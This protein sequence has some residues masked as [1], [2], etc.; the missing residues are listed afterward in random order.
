MSA[1]HFLAGAVTGA[2]VLFVVGAAAASA[3]QVEA[4]HD[5]VAVRSSPPIASPAPVTQIV[6]VHDPGKP[7]TPDACKDYL[8]RVDATVQSVYDYETNIAPA[9]QALSDGLKAIVERD[10]PGLNDVRTR[11]GHIEGMTTGP[12]QVIVQ[13]QPDIV[14]ARDACHKA[15]G[16]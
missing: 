11:I 4:H 1:R 3:P 6:T 10:A 15:L 14:K 2:G 9:N 12:L 13:S 8:A 5:S 16:G 7:F